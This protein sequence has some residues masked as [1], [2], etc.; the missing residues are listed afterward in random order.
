MLTVQ[1][2]KMTLLQS[3]A[4]FF[5]KL[6]DCETVMGISNHGHPPKHTQGLVVL[7]GRHAAITAELLTLKLRQA[8]S[9]KVLK[10]TL[11][12]KSVV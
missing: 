2:L 9:Y 12:R 10:S 5:K 11:D 7:H 6:S 4:K 1:H 3:H 8:L